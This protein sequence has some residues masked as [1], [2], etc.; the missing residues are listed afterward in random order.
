MPNQIRIRNF[1]IAANTA[2]ITL[3]S[4][5]LGLN[6]SLDYDNIQLSVSLGAA[7][8]KFQVELRPVGASF[9]IKPDLAGWELDLDSN[10]IKLDCG[11]D[12]FLAGPNLGAN[13]IV[14][15]AI[16]V[17]FTGNTTACELYVCFIQK[18]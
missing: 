1:D 9:F 2:S 13:G 11:E 10:P 6:P 17:T 4:A 7:G 18:D 12:V 8:S 3:T 16:K 5:N 15:D 14:F